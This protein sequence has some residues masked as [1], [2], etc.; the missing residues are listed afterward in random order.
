MTLRVAFVSMHTSPAEQAGTAD[1]GGMN[2]LIQSLAAALGQQGL[3]VHFIT[4]RSDPA[5]PD[6]VDMG[7]GVVLHH[8]DAGPATPLPKSLIDGHSPAFTAGLRALG[9]FDLMHSH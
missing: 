1:A 4:R 5:Q 9:P 6:T 8:V 7:D 3:S 2:V